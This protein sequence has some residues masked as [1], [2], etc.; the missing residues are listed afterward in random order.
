[1][2][3]EGFFL[4]PSGKEAFLF[5]LLFGLRRWVEMVSLSP[6]AG[7]G[8]GGCRLPLLDA[9]GGGFFFLPPS[10]RAFFQGQAKKC[11]ARVFFFLFSSPYCGTR[12]RG[13][14]PRTQFLAS[15]FFF[16]PRIFFSRRHVVRFSSST[17]AV[18]VPLSFFFLTKEEVSV[19]CLRSFSIRGFL[20]HRKQR[21]DS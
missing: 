1:M 7:M 11:E 15:S 4:F 9:R 3:G 17:V 5:F 8:C 18:K 2:G 12:R 6:E 13:K 14:A 21:L 19:P 16:P 20:P 10:R